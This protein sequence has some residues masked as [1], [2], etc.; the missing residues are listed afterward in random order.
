MSFT[1]A[2]SAS[3]AL[4]M[5]VPPRA[6][7][8]ALF[9][10]ARGWRQS[11]ATMADDFRHHRRT[12]YD[13]P[14]RAPARSYVKAIGFTDDDLARPVV[15]IANTWTGTMPCNFTLRALAQHVARGV[16][17]AGGTP[18]EFNTVAISDGITM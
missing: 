4:I 6:S 2:G 17:E 9:D 13:G 12:L 18:M 8:C 5:V 10:R 16:R 7:R 3:P 15:G 1:S 14:D 11:R